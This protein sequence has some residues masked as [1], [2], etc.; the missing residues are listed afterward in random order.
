MCN[1]IEIPVYLFIYLY[2]TYVLFF[3]SGYQLGLGKAFP[4]LW[5]ARILYNVVT[6]ANGHFPGKQLLCRFQFLRLALSTRVKK[7]IL[8]PDQLQVFAIS[9]V[10]TATYN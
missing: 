2:G 6:I 9:G 3:H 10:V 4:V 1:A 8:Y 7:S 5:G